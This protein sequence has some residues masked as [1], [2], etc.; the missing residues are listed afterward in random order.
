VLDREKFPDL[1]GIVVGA[2]VDPTYP[3]P[4]ISVFEELKHAWVVLPPGMEH[5]PQGRTVGRIV[6][7]SVES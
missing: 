2:F 1:Y 5:F 4:T 6:S 3:A 7:K